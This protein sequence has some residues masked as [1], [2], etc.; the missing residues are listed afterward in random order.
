MSYCQ[1][2]VHSI[3]CVQ[4][5]HAWHN[6]MVVTDQWTDA[7]LFAAAIFS[8]SSHVWNIF[9]PWI[10]FI[11]SDLNT[12][13]SS[14]FSTWMGFYASRK[15]ATCDI[16]YTL[17]TTVLP[18]VGLPAQDILLFCGD[19]KCGKSHFFCLYVCQDGGFIYLPQQGKAVVDH[20]WSS[21]GL[22]QSSHSIAT[23]LCHH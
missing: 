3:L 19:T 21:S 14:G 17:C 7:Y 15:Y 2:Q 4:N 9:R 6:N 5:M 20:G 8:I 13:F 18:S 12:T 22:H 11:V 1:V 10:V 23:C 16:S